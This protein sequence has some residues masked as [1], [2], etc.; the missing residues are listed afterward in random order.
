MKKAIDTKVEVDM[1]HVFGYRGKDGVLCDNLV[2]VDYRNVPE[3]VEVMKLNCL[4]AFSR[5]Q[6]RQLTGVDVVRLGVWCKNSNK[7][8][9]N[10]KP[11]YCFTLGE[12]LFN[13]YNKLNGENNG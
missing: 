11:E 2:C 9:M 6:M 5:A 3:A 10:K 4:M 13:E 1:R 12:D 7:F 8:L